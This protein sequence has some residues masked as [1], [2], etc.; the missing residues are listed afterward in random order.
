[1]VSVKMYLSENLTNNDWD[2]IKRVENHFGTLD[3]PPT[4]KTFIMPGQLPND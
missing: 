3:Y 4:T 2:I 1:M